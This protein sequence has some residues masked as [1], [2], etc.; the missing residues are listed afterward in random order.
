MHLASCGFN[1]H[2]GCSQRIMR[3]VHAAFGRRFFVLLNGHGPLLYSIATIKKRRAVLHSRF[4][5]SQN[6]SG[7]APT[8]QAHVHNLSATWV[9]FVA[10]SSRS[11]RIHLLHSKRMQA[12]CA[13]SGKVRCCCCKVVSNACL[14]CCWIC[15]LCSRTVVAADA[16]STGAE[17]AAAGSVARPAP[18]C[19][20][21]K[22]GRAHV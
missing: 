11:W 18:S 2:I 5:N 7:Y 8:I 22:I 3:T 19:F 21:T 4:D 6:Y 9:C 12:H 16:P 15:W 13:S 10:D 17:A 20:L 1:S 14:Y